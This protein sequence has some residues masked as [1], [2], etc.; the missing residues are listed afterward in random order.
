MRDR[1]VCDKRV[2]ELV[3][4]GRFVWILFPTSS[5][6][7]DTMSGDNYHCPDAKR[8]Q[9]L[10]DIANK[11]RIHCIDATNASN[12]GWELKRVVCVYTATALDSTSVQPV[13]V[14]WQLSKLSEGV[15]LNANDMKKI[16]GPSQGI[17]QNVFCREPELLEE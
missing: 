7:N 4:T 3:D 15:K 6:S 10:R 12:S 13:Y 17:N 5:D 2:V 16:F 11:L 1:V 8:L 14:R 9:T